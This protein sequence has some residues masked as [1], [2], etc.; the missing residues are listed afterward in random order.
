M[1]AASKVLRSA[2]SPRT[3]PDALEMEVAQAIYDLQVS[4]NDL[5][6]DLAPLAI[7]SVKEVEVKGG[8]KALAMYV[9]RNIEQAH[10][11]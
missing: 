2:N 6:S 5:K 8:R 3:A 11:D 10:T 4:V 9:E 7:S 1:S